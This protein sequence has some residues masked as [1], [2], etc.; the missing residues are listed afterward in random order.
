MVLLLWIQAPS[1][2]SQEVST[3]LES[4]CQIRF[5]IDGKVPILI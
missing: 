2:L 1:T 3:A 5:E 4:D